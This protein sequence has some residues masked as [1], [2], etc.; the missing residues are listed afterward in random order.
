[1]AGSQLQA[2]SWHVDSHLGSGI[3][4]QQG[5]TNSPFTYA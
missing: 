4:E 3:P 1:M 2:P 5:Y